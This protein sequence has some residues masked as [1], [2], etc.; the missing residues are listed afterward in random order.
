[1]TRQNRN[2]ANVEDW[3]EVLPEGWYHVRIT[4]VEERTSESSGEPVAMI[5]MKVQE[6][7]FTGR[8]INDFASLQ[9][10]ALAKLKSYYKATGQGIFEDGSD[11]PEALVDGEC[12]VNVSHDM[13]KNQKRLRIAPWGVKSILEG[14]PE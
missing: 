4:K 6:E 1:M 3:G 8:L 9:A 10:H 12:Y 2:I 14:K 13:Y 11:D 5:S 7:P